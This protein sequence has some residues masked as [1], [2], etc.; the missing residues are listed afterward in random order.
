[1]S[2]KNKEKEIKISQV[3][4]GNNE[5]SS[6]TDFSLRN[7]D[8]GE[9]EQFFFFIFLTVDCDVIFREARIS[10]RHRKQTWN[11]KGTIPRAKGTQLVKSLRVAFG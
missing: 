4:L 8:S 1:M 2:S 9:S 6:S 7:A 3:Q 5:H 11:N 10:P